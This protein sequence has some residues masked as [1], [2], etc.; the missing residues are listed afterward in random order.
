[1]LYQLSRANQAWM[2]DRIFMLMFCLSFAFAVGVV[3]RSVQLSREVE[4]RNIAEQEARTLARHDALTGLPNRRVLIEDIEQAIA[5]YER[6]GGS[7]AVLLIDLDRFKPVNDLHGHAAGDI[8]LC[9]VSERLKRLTRKGERVARLG[10]DEFVMVL[11]AGTE[12]A[13]RVAKRILTGLSQPIPIDGIEVA[14]GCTIGVAIYPGDGRDPEELLRAADLAMYR[15]KREERG[16]CRF[17]EQSMDSELRARAA[18]EGEIRRAIPQGQIKPHYQPVISLENGGLLGFEVLARWYHPMRGVL[19]PSEFIAAAEDAGL[20]GELCYGL[21]RQ[22]CLDARDWPR[23]LVLAVNVSPFQL[24][25]PLMPQ[26]ILDILQD[27]GFPPQR[28]EVEITENALAGDLELARSIL[29]T[30]QSQGISVALDDFGT[31]YSSLYQ[32]R[33]LRFNKIKIDRSFVQTMSDDKESAKIVNAV[34]GLGKSLGLL[35]TAEGR[36]RRARRQAHEAR[37]RVRAG[38]PFRAAN[39]DRPSQRVGECRTARH[40][41]A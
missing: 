1:M 32:L 35:T 4:S 34:V 21:L 37:M 6:N 22:A 40:R 3:R 27:T 18:L 24:R 33:E 31:G 28:L 19:A 11:D 2:L 17:F 16:T 38:L 14:V 29:T 25:D 26:K 23:N 41:R 12:H 13:L 8:T 9:E 10:G 5:R 39:G 30:L 7:C 15:A 20:I 36:E